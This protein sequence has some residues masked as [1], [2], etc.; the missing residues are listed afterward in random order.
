MVSIKFVYILSRGKNG[1]L[2]LSQTAEFP[3]QHAAEIRTFTLAP[4]GKFLLTCSHEDA[5]VKLWDLQGGLLTQFDTK[6]LRNNMACISPNS[7][8]FT[9][10][11]FTGDVRIWEIVTKKGGGPWEYSDA[12]KAMDLSGHKSSVY[13]V[14]FSPD[15]HK[16]VTASKDCTWRMWDID[17]RYNVGEDP[18]CLFSIKTQAALDHIVFSPDQSTIAAATNARLLFYDGSKGQL[19]HTINSAHGGKRLTRLVW[20][21]DS[22]YLATVAEQDRVVRLW[23]NPAHTTNQ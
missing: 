13:A 10:A 18:K 14:C 16:V 11:T 9:V 8:F 6:K 2:V 17:V 1:Q 4:N 3:S 21:A 19:L 15:S 12:V 22:K 5:I 23:R 7:K 20:S